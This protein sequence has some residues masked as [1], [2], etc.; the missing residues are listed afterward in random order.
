M[1]RELK[2]NDCQ[3][4]CDWRPTDE[5]SD[6]IQLFSCGG[7]GSEWTADQGWTPRNGDG[8][9][10]AEVAAARAAAQPRAAADTPPS[11]G[12]AGK[13]FGGTSIGSW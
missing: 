5:V 13:G 12:T 3:G 11:Q 6:G 10:P 9:V 7:C 4:T 1:M 8:E 2:H